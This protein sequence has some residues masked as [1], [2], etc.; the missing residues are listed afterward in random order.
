MTNSVGNETNRQK[1]N[2]PG[3]LSEK[4]NESTF[5]YVFVIVIL[6]IAATIVYQIFFCST[7]YG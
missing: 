4:N 1:S 3:P 7:C 6:G 2:N 5:K